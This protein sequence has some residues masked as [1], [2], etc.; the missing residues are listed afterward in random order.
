MSVEDLKQ[1]LARYRQIKISVV[2]R[3][4]G[5]SVSI[6]VWF[7]LEDDTLYLLPVQGSD[8]Q[9]Y[10]NVLRNPSIGI[11]VRDAEAELKAVPVTGAKTVASIVEKFRAKYGAGDVKKYYSK[12]DVAVT[13]DFPK[14]AA[15]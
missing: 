6:P 12:F 4:S 3:K 2:G 14:R 5:R 13:V 7:V 10:K 8:T 15:R 9:W 1:R 11:S